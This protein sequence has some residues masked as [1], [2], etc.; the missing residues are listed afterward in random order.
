MSCA[1]CDIVSLRA[2]VAGAKGTLILEK[3]VIRADAADCIALPLN[4]SNTDA[5]ESIRVALPLVGVEDLVLDFGGS[6]LLCSG[7]IVP[8]SLT[9]CRNITLRNLVIDWEIPLSA[10][11]VVTESSHDRIVVRIDGATFPYTVEDGDLYFLGNGHKAGRH[12]SHIPFAP[13]TLT[14]TAAGSDCIAPTGAEDLGD[15]LVAMT[16]KFDYPPAP[17]DLMVIRH[18]PRENAGIFAEDCCGLIFE[19]ITVHCCGGLGI[20]C[21][22]NRDL[23]FRRVR[24]AANGERGRRVVGGHDDGLHLTC[25]RGSILVEGSYFHG[26]MDDPIN[27]HGLCA[28]I[29]GVEGRT[30]TGRFVHPQA[31]GF[32]LFA[33]V[34]DTLSVID[35]NPMTSRGYGVAESYT[36]LDRETFTVTFRDELPAGT[37]PGDALDNLSATCDFTC[38]DNCFASCRA[39]GILIS[40]PGKVLVENNL[41]QSAGSAILIPGDANY[42]Y[43]SGACTDVTIRRNT[44]TSLCLTAMYEYCHGIISIAPEVP[45]PQADTPFHRNI[46]IEENTFHLFQAPWLF[47]FSTGNLS[48][49]RNRIFECPG[50]A[51]WHPCK[52]LITLRYCREVSIADNVL[53]GHIPGR[54]IVLQDTDPDQVQVSQPSGSELTVEQAAYE[55]RPAR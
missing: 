20:L 47:A 18:S 38:R 7:R 41:F 37:V 43:E 39:R 1:I 36:L 15:G 2:A 16:G 10:E 14:V 40:V 48:I 44:F 13:D 22:F 27:V 46:T 25:N 26:L 54:N 35:N 29:I 53:V 11:G 5:A 31:Q 28:R 50:Y 42:W 45:A 32:S 12:G 3:S 55:V 8:I 30:V 23:I 51:P 6:T 24:F 34:G 17:G 21:Q 33:R 49:A 19:D 4:Q 9:G 52:D